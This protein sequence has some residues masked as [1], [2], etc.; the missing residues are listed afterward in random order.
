MIVDNYAQMLRIVNNCPDL[1]GKVYTDYP[2]ARTKA[3]FAVVKRISNTPDCVDV[4]EGREVINTLYYSVDIYA[5]DNT[6]VQELG[7]FVIGLYI[8]YNIL[9][10]GDIPIRSSAKDLT[11]RSLTLRLQLNEYGYVTQ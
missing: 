2:R 5:Q 4:E 6:S 10:A 7:D 1:T 3:P 9:K 11:G 8:P